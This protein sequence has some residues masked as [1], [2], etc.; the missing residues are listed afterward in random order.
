MQII[1]YAVALALRLGMECPNVACLASVEVIIE[2]M[3]ETIDAAILSK[4]NEREQIKGCR[5]DVPLAGF[6]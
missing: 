2:K 1:Q 3:Q 5:I 4:A 6:Q